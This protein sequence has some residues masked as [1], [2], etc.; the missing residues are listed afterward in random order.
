[1]KFRERFD[2]KGIFECVLYAGIVD[3]LCRLKRRGYRIM[4]AS[5]KHEDAC[6]RI[7]E[8]F[9]LKYCFDGIFGAA[10]IGKDSSKESVL[11][12]LFQETG[13][14][15]GAS[16]LIGDTKFDVFGAKAVRIPCIGVTYGF[17]S[18]R[19]LELAGA[20]FICD[21]PKEIER[22]LDEIFKEVNHEGFSN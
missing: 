7:I 1:M 20:R 5:S 18:R 2:R 9:H 11:N 21:N 3:V 4:L 14:D 13:I 19:E 16:V 17:G 12:H 8:H 22:L 15:P 6:V 10:G